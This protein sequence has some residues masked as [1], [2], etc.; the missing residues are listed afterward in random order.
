MHRITKISIALCSYTLLSTTPLLAAKPMPLKQMSFSKL[1]QDFQVLLPNTNGTLNEKKNS[2]MFIKQRKDDKRVTHVR[3]QQQ[4]AGFPVFRGYAIFHSKQPLNTIISH[5]NN[6]KMNGQ[7]YKDLEADLGAMPSSFIQNKAAALDA[8]KTFYPQGKISEEEV[9]PMVYVNKN[10]RA[11]WAYQIS[12]LVHYDNKIPERPTAIV[13][14]NHYKPFAQW[15]DI[16]TMKTNARAVGFGGNIRTRKYEFGKNL[17][18]LYVS[19]NDRINICYM[20]NQQVKVVDMEHQ[21]YHA[22]LPMPF[23]CESPV[24][25]RKNVYW[26]GQ[27]ADGYDLQNGSYSPS[28]D[29]LY[30]GYVISRMY[31]R[32]YNTPALVSRTG[33]PKQLIMRVHFGD[34]YENAFWDGRQMTFGDGGDLM[35]PLVSIGVAAHEISHGFTQQHSNLAYFGES[36]GMNEAFSDMAAQ[37]AEYYFKRS[38]SWKIGAEIMKEESGYKALR[39]MK[40]PSLDG[41]SIDRADEYYDGLDVHHASGVY[42]RLFYL[43][44]HQPDWSTRKAFDVMVKANMDY[45]TPYSTFAEGACGVINAARDLEYSLSAVKDSLVKVGLNYE[46]CDDVSLI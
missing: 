5:G 37:A 31:K 10:H 44:A 12:F 13:D 17:P 2:L 30:A 35:H 18:Y 41:Q 24:K 14:A 19:R 25:G 20:E 46:A 29:A 11:F 16:Q 27:N 28:N 38:S 9:I 34:G 22:N 15:N 26:S 23:P 45:W 4:F 36:G 8:L 21:Y 6:I 1:Q 33:Q 32:W 42:N 43:M 40:Q 39:Y 7:L 3:M